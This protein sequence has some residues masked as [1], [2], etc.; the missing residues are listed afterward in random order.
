MKVNNDILDQ[1]KVFGII[2]AITAFLL[3]IPAVGSQF[4][5]D[6]NWTA[7]DYIAAGLLI[8]TAFTAYVLIARRVK[9]NKI[10]LAGIILVV[11]A[12]I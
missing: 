9:K 11:F 3:L 10:L 8:F 6:M 12:Y 2:A 5:T 7:S 1:N 4:Y